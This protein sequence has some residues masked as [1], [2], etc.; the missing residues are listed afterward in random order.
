MMLQ[1]LNSASWNCTLNFRV[2][3]TVKFEMSNFKVRN[4][5]KY[6]KDSELNVPEWSDLFKLLLT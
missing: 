1:N 6:N 5:L 4:T 2:F 3:S